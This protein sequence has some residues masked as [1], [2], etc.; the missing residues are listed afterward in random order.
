MSPEPKIYRTSMRGKD[1]QERTMKGN[2]NKKVT[3][4]RLCF[5]ELKAVNE[6]R[7]KGTTKARSKQ[8][9]K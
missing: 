8:G 2:G 4:K 9:R 5:E 3:K 7:A 6:K 1:R